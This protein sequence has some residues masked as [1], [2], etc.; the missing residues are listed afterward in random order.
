MDDDEVG[1]EGLVFNFRGREICF[2]DIAISYGEWTGFYTRL[3]EEEQDISIFEIEKFVSFWGSEMICVLDVTGGESE[4]ESGSDSYL[5]VFLKG[6]KV[7]S[8]WYYILIKYIYAYFAENLWF[9]E[10][11]Y[12]RNDCAVRD[13]LSERDR[14]IGDE[15][16]RE[17][18]IEHLRYLASLLLMVGEA[19]KGVKDSGNY[20]KV[21]NHLSFVYNILTGKN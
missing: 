2:D 11:A 1:S 5:R 15:V 16:G 18:V 9:L 13:E 17:E 21:K 3:D 14:R 19:H 4:R 6:G 12:F 8:H 10:L 20:L 7:C